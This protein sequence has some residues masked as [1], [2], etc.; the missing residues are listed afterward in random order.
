MRF[1]GC[2][3]V[4]AFEIEKLV[5]SGAYRRS[6]FLIFNNSLPLPKVNIFPSM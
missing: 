5:D 1:F 2:L 4:L 3:Y 6:L